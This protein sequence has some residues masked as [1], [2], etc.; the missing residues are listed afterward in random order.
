[1]NLSSSSVTE[2]VALDE[3]DVLERML[4]R[5]ASCRGFLSDPV[6]E[7]LMRRVLRIAQRTASWCNSQPWQVVVASGEAME[8]LRNA[9]YARAAAG[10]KDVTDIAFPREYRGIY[11]DRR[12]ET[13]FQL[14]EAMGVARDDKDGRLRQTLENF[15]M[16]GAPHVA[17]ITTAEALGPYGAI[18]CG[19]YVANFLLAIEAAGLGAIAQAA[20]AHHSVFIRNH[21][22]LSDERRVVCGISF[23]F[24]DLSHPA[25]TVR[26]GR[27]SVDDAVRVVR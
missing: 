4:N 27:A 25:N 11:Q 6:P 16:F 18:D 13:G 3:L 24:P 20:L 2:A 10:E 22:G 15:R 9:I 1:M 5:R 19:A 21:F 23:G 26:T 12:R 8:D 17:I 7:A 14:Y